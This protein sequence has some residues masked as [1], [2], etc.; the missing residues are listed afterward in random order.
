MGGSTSGTRNVPEV[1]AKFTSLE[2][3]FHNCD[4]TIGFAIL[5]FYPIPT[6]RRSTMN[7]APDLCYSIV[8]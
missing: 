7:L 2:S 4:V 8:R 6:I 3:L 1:G 5:L